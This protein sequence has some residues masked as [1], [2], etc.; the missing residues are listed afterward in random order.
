MDKLWEITMGDL[1]DYQA[2]RY[3]DQDCV[4]YN[5]RPFRLTYKGFRDLVN[6]TA[7]G[8]LRL[9]VKKGDHVAIWGANVPQ[10]LLTM[11]ATAKIG[12]VMVTVNTAYKVFEAEYLLRQSDTH[13]LVMTEGFKDSDYVGIVNELAPELAGSRPGEWVSEGLPRLR[14]VIC[15]GGPHDGML[16]WDALYELGAEV[17]DAELAAAQKATDIHDVVNMQYTSGTTGFPKGVML[18][19]HNILNNGNSIGDCMKFSPA[20]RLCITVPLFH[21][22]GMVLAVMASVTHAVAMVMVETFSPAVVLK[23]LHEEKCTA[24]HGVPTMFIAMMDHPDFAGV[25]FSHMRTG[26]MAGSPCPVKVMRQVVEEMNMRE[27]TIV[28]GLTE[29]SPGC[30]Q[31]RTDDSLDLRV[32]TVGRNLP[33]VETRIVD[34][35]TGEI[36]PPG[37]PGEFMARGYNIMKGYYNMPEATSQAITPDGWLHSGDIATV[38]EQGYYKI[39]GR[40]KDMII[41]GGENIYPKEIEE[42][43]YTHP[44]VQDVQVIGVPSEAYGEE[45][46]AYVIL[47]AGEAADQET[48][49]TFLRERIARHKVPKYIGFIGEF[50]MT[51]SGKIQ[52]FKLRD[53]AV[54]EL[55][56]Q[57]AANIETA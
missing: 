25:D 53:M 19:H 9:G 4:L 5:D 10:W 48:L 8:F 43:L 44:A 17:S 35:E 2:E 38:D 13:T 26:I 45:V 6:L 20:D 50:P 55:S 7:K 28:Y 21:C 15:C 51:A 56:L 46:M 3:P 54:A 33:F 29:S 34:P 47:K 49:R 1:L 30:T 37:V 36:C 32:A 11:W 18:S 40:I 23:A 57:D 14:N 31:T 12:A 41:R 22:F 52:K 39:T 24:V 16:P 42:C 27:I